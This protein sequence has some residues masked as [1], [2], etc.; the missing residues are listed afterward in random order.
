M[1]SPRNN[2]RK[3]ADTTD[4]DGPHRPAPPLR[5]RGDDRNLPAPVWG[6]VLDYMPYDEVR[7]A[8]L[9]GEIVANEAVKYVHALNITKVCQMD[10]PSTRRFPNIE[11]LNILC[12]VSAQGS[13]LDQR[14]CQETANKFVPFLT[15]FKKL[16]RVFAG[17][18]RP[19]D[20]FPSGLRWFDS[21]IFQFYPRYSDDQHK[22]RFSCL[23]EHILGAYKVRMLPKSIKEMNG[24]IWLE[25]L[26]TRCADNSS[27]CSFCRDVCSYFPVMHTII[28]AGI[29][30]LSEIE[31]YRVISKRPDFSKSVFKE[32]SVEVLVG[33]LDE[34]IDLFRL[35]FLA[36]NPADVEL[37]ERL[38]NASLNDPKDVLYMTANGLREIDDLIEVGFDPLAIS[39]SELYKKFDIGN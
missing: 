20:F 32:Y 2:K 17:G 30:C 12:L 37:R 16:E 39:K 22:R 3:A 35:D 33:A 36:T 14:V 25:K 23:V 19:V 31:A 15:F 8:L 38:K 9:V 28:D 5:S 24:I 29:V 7:S 6:H 11:E 21:M 10:G 26:P 18:L 13:L 4:K 1:S 34:R 27:A